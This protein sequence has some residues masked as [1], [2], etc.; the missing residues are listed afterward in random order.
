VA[1]HIR[2]ADRPSDDSKDRSR[3]DS[4]DVLRGLVMVVM[5]LDHTREYFH[6]SPA[7]LDATDPAHSNLILFATRWVTYFCAPTFVLLTGASVWL[8]GRTIAWPELF[9]FLI[10]RGAW[11]ILLE[12]TFVGTGF[13]FHPGYL[14][15]QVIWVIGASLILLAF[16]SRLPNGAV[17]AIGFVILAGHDLL[18][19]MMA[20]RVGGQAGLLDFLDGRFAFVAIGP[21]KGVLL[22]SLLGWA[23]IMFV[24]YGVAPVF[25]WARAR[26]GHLLAAIGLAMILVF[27]VL[28]WINRYGDPFPWTA[29]P[30]PSRTV[31]AFLRVSKYPP[32]LDFVLAT[33]GPMLLLLAFLERWRGRAMEV[34]RTFGRV[35]F[36]YY[37]LHI[38]LIHAAAAALGLLQGRRFAEFTDPLNPPSG[39]GLPLWGV[40]LCWIAIVAAL[41]PACR[42]FEALRQRRRDWWLSYL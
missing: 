26:R 11:L 5:A 14:F 22:Y 32:S 2:V 38:Y 10:G 20:G 8:R 16:L 19:P 9:R 13:T 35:P 1:E 39:F 23:G 25:R 15:L 41:Y 29:E 12:L 4:I 7:G 6:L 36:F 17:L 18:D 21:L 30:T 34:F 37:L 3:I 42:W 40:Y 24:G 27:L 31:M 28:R 33:L